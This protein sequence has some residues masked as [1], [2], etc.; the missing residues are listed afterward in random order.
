[1]TAS[2]FQRLVLLRVACEGVIGGL[3]DEEWRRGE[4]VG[5]DRLIGLVD[6]VEKE[7]DRLT[8]S[9]DAKGRDGLFCSPVNGR[10]NGPRGSDV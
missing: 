4:V 2:L 10:S 9:V 3:Q 1:M 8:V 6:A 5:M 7:V